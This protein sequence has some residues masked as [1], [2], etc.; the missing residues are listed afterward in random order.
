[1]LDMLRNTKL[2]VQ[3]LPKKKYIGVRIGGIRKVR[4]IEILRKYKWKRI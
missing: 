1:M 3:T 2:I 4:E